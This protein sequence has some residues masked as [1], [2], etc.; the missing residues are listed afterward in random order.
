MENNN[1]HIARKI[2]IEGLVQGV[3]FRPFIYRLALENKIKGYVLNLND[4]VEILAEGYE[5][6]LENFIS[7]ISLQKPQASDIQHIENSEVPFTGEKDFSIRKSESLDNSVT[8]ISPDI[9]VCPD[10]LNDIKIQSNRLN[11]PLVNCTNCGPR[12][13][14]VRSIP[15]DRHNTTMDTFEMCGNCRTEYEEILDRRF[16][17][18]PVA[19]N[20]CGPTYTLLAN[21]KVYQLIDDILHV[22]S[23]LLING[24]IIALKGTGGFHLMCNALDK[25]AV[26]NLRNRKIREGKPFAVMFRDVDVLKKYAIVS[27]LEEHSLLSWQRPVVILKSIKNFPFPVAT[28]LDTVG[29]IL[30][31]MPFHFLFFE[32]S[33]LDAVVF[34]SGNVS[35][36]PVIIDNL[37]AEK[38]LST[39][40]DALITYNREIHNRTDDSVIRIMN[41][42]ERIF[43]RS[44][45]YAPSPVKVMANVEGILATGAE[46]ANCFCI[47]KENQAIL[48]QHIGDLK[49]IETYQFY[50]ETIEKYKKLF[51]FNPVFV[52]CDMHPDY[53]STKYAF[54][55]GIEKIE[56]QHHHAHIA[57]CMAENGLDEKV[58]GVSFDG[59]GY[60]TD[61]NIWGS[62]FFICD[63]NSFERYTHFDYLSLP[64]GDIVVDQPWRTAIS[65]L[66][67]T[68]GINLSSLNIPFINSLE[69]KKMN[70]VIQALEKNINCPLSSGAGRLFDAVAALLNICPVT[71][72]HAEAPMKLEPY[73]RND[74]KDRYEIQ[75]NSVISFKIMFRQIVEDIFRKLDKDVIVT[76]FHNTIIFTIL[77]IA[78]EIRKESG[79]KKIVLSGGV[80]QNKYI[81]E[82]L[83]QLLMRH[84]FEVYTHSRV[85]ANDGGI[86]L[87]QIM[88]A[89]KKRN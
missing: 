23:Q 70:M 2:K 76:K 36:E 51:R 28:G 3:G 47:G 53:L 14:I 49:N 29:A 5:G 83:E 10:C 68:F 60:G 4:G 88:I 44:R 41:G 80:F 89:S 87:G 32:K 40:A 59:T 61:G 31:Y 72:Y 35:D 30:P 85:P 1:K 43:R 54:E 74:I 37:I 16:H 64:G 22:S 82:N 33:L 81:S 39:I 18:Q 11:Y 8:Q 66:Y 71:T 45:G 24:K 27:P 58:I 56:I 34:T 75:Y 57:S 13:S 78:S 26:S 73:I 69:E 65:C 67:N 25:E 19:C 48:S 46:L 9:A 55:T 62:E 63:Y 17:A 42:K 12:F 20:H 6:S 79:I 84:H 52:A 77:K 86:S 15:Y 7:S 21:K 38:N 50:L